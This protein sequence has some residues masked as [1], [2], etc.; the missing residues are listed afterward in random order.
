[1]KN[2]PTLELGLKCSLCGIKHDSSS[3]NP[4]P[5]PS[6]SPYPTFPTT[7]T[8]TMNKIDP[9]P[10]RQQELDPIETGSKL[11]CPVCTFLNHHSMNR[12][13]MCDTL[14]PTA[15]TTVTPRPSTP[16]SNTTSRPNTP[17]GGGSGSG[18]EFVR[19]SFRKGGI[20][21]FYT[22]LKEQLSRKA[23]DLG[24]SQLSP[25]DKVKLEVLKRKQQ[26]QKSNG[27]GNEL[28]KSSSGV[29]IG[30]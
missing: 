20:N 14:L 11:S 27:N 3:S 10:P 15:T 8:T 24:N 21:Q 4:P 2:L 25:V 16:S 30:E 29:G 19:L 22:R 12:C 5:A 6:I 9:P 26:Q 18:G 1:M 7:T 17:S 13:E 23:W 28:H